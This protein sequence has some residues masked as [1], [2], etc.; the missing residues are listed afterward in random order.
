MFR[1]AYQPNVINMVNSSYENSISYPLL[2]ENSRAIRR[3]KRRKL[4]K[5][6]KTLNVAMGN[7][8]LT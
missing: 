8:Y 6:G 1:V 7:F 2:S 5:C 3:Q 4:S